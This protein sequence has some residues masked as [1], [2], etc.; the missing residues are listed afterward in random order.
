MDFRNNPSYLGTK[1]MLAY[2]YLFISTQRFP[3][4]AFI[5]HGKR[6]Y[7]YSELLDAS[8]TL[9]KW[10]LSKDIQSSFR[11]AILTD[12]PFEY[13]SSYFAILI[14]GGIAVG[15]NTQTSERTLKTILNDCKPTI[16]FA[17][18]KFRGYIEKVSD[19]I[20]SLTTVVLSGSNNDLPSDKSSSWFDCTQIMKL[21]TADNFQPPTISPST[22][23]QIIYTSGTTGNPKGVMLRHSNLTANTNS[24][25]E[26]LR[27]TDKDRVMAVLPFFYSYGNSVLLTHIAVGG[28]M[29]VNQNFL[30]PN[31]ILD[32][33]VR[34]NVTG[35]SGVPSTYA[36]LLNRSAIR[37]YQF[38]KLRYVTQ[39]GAAM[40]PKLVHSLKE[41]M[42]TTDIFI[43]YGQTEATAR[44]SYLD[45][46][47][48][49]RKA[50]SIGKAIPGVTLQILERGGNPVQASGE[51]GEIVAQ[52]DN[53]MNG[54]WEKPEETAKALRSGYLHTGDLAKMAE[55][56]FLYIVSRKN[57][58]IKSG[59]HRIAPKE[60]EEII[61]EHDAVHEV[62]VV[63][64]E[65]DILGESIKA[66]IVSK[67]DTP[68]NAKEII[69][70]CRRNLPAYKIPHHVTFY[71]E[72][73][74]TATGKICKGKL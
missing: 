51:V 3:D 22:V 5:I 57:D 23:A 7:T 35:F 72:L 31:V 15:M 50:G 8:L 30:Y 16:A 26:Y 65:D 29:V 2:D 32:E 71:D 59:S 67:T 24:I 37:Q 64:I 39:A 53:I 6:R 52:G 43:M 60:I 45:P 21:T 70:H 14:A 44:L 25:V 47:E 58:M 56:G 61:L 34:E 55:E 20:P 11:A 4:K 27:L 19:T 48:I 38:P 9:A 68:F 10:L 54:Y 66:C 62:A 40:S 28:S 74:K 12:N 49:Y 17:N 69:L 33:M 36:I 63:G 46:Q 18:S 42:P 13:I 73:P 41:I 1:N